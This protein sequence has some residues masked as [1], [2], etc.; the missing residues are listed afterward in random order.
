MY[1]RILLPLKLSWTPTYSSDEELMR[2]MRVRVSFSHKEYIGI[3]LSS[4]ATLDGFSPE[5][6]LPVLQTDTG[7]PPVSEQELSLWE[8]IAGY[9]ACTLGEVYKAAYPQLKTNSELILAKKAPDSKRFAPE[10]AG[11]GG[12]KP[13]VLLSPDRTGQYIRK[14]GKC[15]ED[16]GEALVLVPETALADTLRKKLKTAFKDR[17][18]IFNSNQ[19]AAHRRETAML[20]RS[21]SP[22]VVL[23]TRSSIFLPFSNLRLVIIDEEQDSSYKQSEPNPRYNGRDTAVVLAGIHGAEVILGTS[24]P[25]FETLHNIY[26]GKYLAPGSEACYSSCAPEIIDLQKEQRK[27]GVKAAFSIILSKQINGC[28]GSICLVRGWE[29][30][31]EL[32][33][34]VEAFYPGKDICIRT[35]AAVRNGSVHYDLLAVL[36]ADAF[37]DSSDFRSDEK[38]LQLLS[39]LSSKADRT[40]IQ[41]FKAE[42][43]VFAVLSGKAD[44]RTMMEEREDFN[45]PPYSRLMDIV[46]ND[47]SPKRLEMFENI[48]SGSFPAAVKIREEGR[49]R[50]RL[51]LPKGRDAR[52]FKVSAS[53]KIKQI[54]ESYRYFGHIH[55]DVDPS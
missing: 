30:E 8:F 11:A 7:L 40:I 21:G 54:E 5:K 41:T 19:T 33:A 12:R 29:K 38:A 34:T 13:E 43:P 18:R 39:R 50:L 37:F 31:E 27:N 49:T 22:I 55:L 1:F 47:S 52:S 53:L 6:I 16:N 46:L 42:H 36:Q 14:I 32:Q 4:S 44:I 24:T 3:I 17:L 48:L 23:G 25:S 20:L 10:N 45:L 9:Y 15:L 28:E 2:G 26:T 35:A 51:T